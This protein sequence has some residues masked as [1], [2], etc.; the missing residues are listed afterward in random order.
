VTNLVPGEYRQVSVARVDFPLRPDRLVAHFAGREVYRRTRFIV[1]RSGTDTAVVEV[2]KRSTEELLS[3]A[4]SVEV[5]ASPDESVWLDLPDVD[6]GVPSELADAACRHAPGARCVVVEGRYRHVSF[7]LEPSPLRVRVADV[8][9]PVPGK[10]AD[11]AARVLAV[12]EDLP[13]IQLVPDMVDL[14]ELAG[15]WADRFDRFLLPCRGSGFSFPGRQVDFLDERPPRQE[16]VLFGCARSRALHR[17][18]YGDLPE[19]AELC[20]RLRSYPSGTP[21]LTKC[22]LLEDHSEV[23]G[24]AVVVPWGASLDLVREAL[25]TLATANHPSWSPA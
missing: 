23:D 18:F 14:S 5:L 8:V 16:W 22:C 17:W 6:T 4:T 24:D 19:T 11:Q 1:V 3:P 2:G 9:P 21:V 20:P 10:L 15:Q 7:I 12:A 13:P 25:E